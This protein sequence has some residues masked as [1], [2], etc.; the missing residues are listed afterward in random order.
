MITPNER[1][2][3]LLQVIQYHVLLD[4]RDEVMHKLL[5]EEYTSNEQY[6]KLCERL[7]DL[8]GEILVFRNTADVKS[9]ANDY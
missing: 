1:Y 4:E 7:D 3:R 5:N 2:E 9:Y 6:F 8:E